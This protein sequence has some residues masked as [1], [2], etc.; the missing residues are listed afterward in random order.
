[1][2]GGAEFPGCASFADRDRAT[3]QFARL[4]NISLGMGCGGRTQPGQSF[5]LWAASPVVS[6]PACYGRPVGT[7]VRSD[8]AD[9]ATARQDPG[10]AH[11]PKSKAVLISVFDRAASMADSLCNTQLGCGNLH[12][13]AMPGN[14]VQSG[15]E[16]VMIDLDSVCAGPRE[17]DLV[18]MY[19]MAKRFSRN[20]ERRWCAFLNGHGANEG[21]LSDLHAASIIKQLSMTT[22]LCLSAGQS[23]DIDAEIAQRARMWAT[24]D[25]AGRWTTGF[26]VGLPG[27]SAG[28]G[29]AFGK[30]GSTRTAPKDF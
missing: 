25:L 30:V 27:R 10:G 3:L 19:V 26:T 16:M 22:Y 1:M 20:G 29:S 2:A 6:R 12:G 14:A 9:P 23:T 24:W 21:D 4:P 5:R 18:P 7:G 8:D 15:G 28:Q 13:D 11:R 17:W